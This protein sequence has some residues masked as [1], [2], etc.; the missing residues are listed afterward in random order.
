M[1]NELTFY[2]FPSFTI[3]ATMSFSVGSHEELQT[4]MNVTV[5][6]LAGFCGLTGGEN[7]Q[8]GGDYRSLM[9]KQ[10]VLD[11]NWLWPRLRI[12]HQCLAWHSSIPTYAIAEKNS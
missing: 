3:A 6:S 5:E 8:A 4:I 9:L 2:Y 12:K 1:P 7:Q 11:V 10:Q